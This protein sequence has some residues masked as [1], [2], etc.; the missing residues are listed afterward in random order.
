MSTSKLLISLLVYSLSDGTKQKY[1]PCPAFANELENPT[2]N[3]T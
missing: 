1:K 2:N 3:F